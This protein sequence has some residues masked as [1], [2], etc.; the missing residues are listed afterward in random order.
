MSERFTFS[1]GREM[2]PFWIWKTMDE[3]ERNICNRLAKAGPL[4]WN[5]R[6]LSAAHIKLNDVEG[7]IGEGV[8]KKAS[9]L[10]IASEVVKNSEFVEEME[11]LE[12][13]GG[14]LAVD[15]EGK[16]FIRS[17]E[18]AQ[19]IAAGDPEESQ[20]ECFQLSNGDLYQ[21]FQLY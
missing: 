18:L 14:F 20:E 12:N 6:S 5:R 16:D 4:G 1:D 2:N 9:L 11:R 3:N 17:F 7:L 13:E 15:K 19:Q 21:F 10:K 8:V